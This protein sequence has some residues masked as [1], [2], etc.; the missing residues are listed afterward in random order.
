MELYCQRAERLITQRGRDNY[1][2]A[3]GLFKKARDLLVRG[4]QEVIWVRYVSRVRERHRL[5]RALQEELNA[6]GM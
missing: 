3:C 2:A 6:A 4:G 1:R 5:L